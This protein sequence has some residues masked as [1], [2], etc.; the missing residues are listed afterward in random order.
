MDHRLR[1]ELGASAP[2]VR[3]ITNTPVLLPEFSA[4]ARRRLCRRLAK[5]NIGMHVSSN[6]SEVGPD[7]VRLDTG[8]DF[9]SD[10]TFWAAGAG[11]Q[12]WIRE[13]GFATDPHGFLLTNDCLQSVTY[14][15]VFGAGDC[16]VQEGHPRAKAGVF[17]VRAAPVLAANL[18]AAVGGGQLAKF[19]TDPR[20]LALVATGPRHAVGTWNG[21]SWEGGWAWRW[22]DRIDRRFVARYA[23]PKG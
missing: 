5:R 21:Y 22:K 20:Y 6:V 19:R 17:A 23:V 13:S 3:V 1:R 16:A 11:A 18:R 15:E 8:I 4:S 12:E 9:A 7:H 14:R 10:A 2:H